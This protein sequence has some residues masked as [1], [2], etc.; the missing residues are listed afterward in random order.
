[1]AGEFAVHLPHGEVY[2]ADEGKEWLHA[3]GWEHLAHQPLTGPVSLLS[4]RAV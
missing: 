4:A 2:S 1:M 3:T